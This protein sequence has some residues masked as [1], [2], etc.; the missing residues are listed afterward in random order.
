MGSFWI[1]LSTFFISCAYV[2]IKAI[3]LS[4]VF[5]EIFLLRSIVVLSVAV[6]LVAATKTSLKTHE[7]A[8]QF[9]RALCGVGALS[10]NILVVRHILL[11]T[12][13]MLQYTGPLFLGLWV[14]GWYLFKGK[15]IP[16]MLFVFF[17]DRICR[18]LA[19]TQTGCCR[20]KCFV[21]RSRS[22]FRSAKFR[23]R[24]FFTTIRTE[25]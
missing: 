5:Y 14:F 9:S 2:S 17:G 24:H 6:C 18:R 19:C 8:L 12:A 7:P 20:S 21:C 15:K 13:Q 11:S 3:P 22:F 23:L 16:W 4:M 10:I 25:R 1:V